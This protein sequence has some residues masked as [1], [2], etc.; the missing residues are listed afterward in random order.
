MK[1]EDRNRHSKRSKPWFSHACADVG[2]ASRME[3]AQQIEQQINAYQ[4]HQ[5]QLVEDIKRGL[6]DSSHVC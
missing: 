3:R 5:Q 2:I 6:S 4:Q 1:T